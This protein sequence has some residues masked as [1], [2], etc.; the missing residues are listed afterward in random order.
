MNFPDGRATGPSF[1]GIKVLGDIKRVDG[2]GQDLFGQ[3]E[4]ISDIIR[5]S[6]CVVGVYKFIC[7]EMKIISFNLINGLQLLKKLLT[8]HVLALK[9]TSSMNSRPKG[10]QVAVVRTMTKV[11]AITIANLIVR[12]IS[13]H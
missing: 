6:R 10:D 4:S 11:H 2:T 7:L 1:T 8:V 12:K 13:I 5:T 3:T 9:F